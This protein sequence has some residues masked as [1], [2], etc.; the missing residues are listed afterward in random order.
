MPKLTQTVVPEPETAPEVDT[1][2]TPGQQ[3]SIRQVCRDYQLLDQQ[4]KQLE[5]QREAKKVRLGELRNEVGV[6]SLFFEGFK[7]TLV[8]GVRQ[9]LNKKRLI[10]LG[11]KQAWLEEATEAKASKPYE[12]VTLPGQRD[13]RSAEED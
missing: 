10:A 2:L 7:V 1:D 11:C 13:H 6:I 12:K 4:I 9:V 5:Q 3:L 8:G